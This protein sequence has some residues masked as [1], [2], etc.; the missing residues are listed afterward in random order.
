MEEKNALESIK[1]LISKFNRLTETANNTMAARAYEHAAQ[2]V[3][4]QFIRLVTRPATTP[5]PMP[6]DGQQ[7]VLP[8]VIK[9]L[10]ARSI[11]GV[12]KYGTVL[13]T[14]NGRNCLMDAYQESLDL[15][16]YLKQRLMEME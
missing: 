9:D 7:E 2:M 16:A 3:E 14:H 6:I 11:I 15:A 13:K 5:E 12:K 1:S 4:G 10:Q 8:E